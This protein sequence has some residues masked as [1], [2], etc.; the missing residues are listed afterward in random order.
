MPDIRSTLARYKRPLRYVMGAFYVVAGTMHFVLPNVYVQIIPPFFPRRLALVYLSGLA[1][2]GLG[3]G[4]MLP[5]TRRLAAWGLIALLVA[6][7]PANIYMATHDVTL[8][9]V[10]AWASDPS[11]ATA[12]ARLPFQAVFILWAYWYTQP[13]TTH[14]E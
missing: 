11:D 12:W 5:R 10:P 7:F 2:V 3:I 9:G 4:V 6:I 1:E 8:T 13:S 14:P